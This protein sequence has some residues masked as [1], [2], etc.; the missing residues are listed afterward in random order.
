MKWKER[1]QQCR[2]I[3]ERTMKVVLL[4]LCSA[5]FNFMPFSFLLTIWFVSDYSS[6]VSVGQRQQLQSR[7]WPY[8]RIITCSDLLML[9]SPLPPPPPP[10]TASVGGQQQQSRGFYPGRRWICSRSSDSFVRLVC[11]S[12]RRSDPLR[13]PFPLCSAPPS[14]SSLFRSWAQPASARVAWI[15]TIHTHTHTHWQRIPQSARISH[16]KLSSNQWL[17]DQ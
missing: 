5:S 15:D 2:R 3:N 13:D 12:L 1:Q 7:S 16:R 9:P 14:L 4:V 17:F 8:S 6:D 11:P 10:P